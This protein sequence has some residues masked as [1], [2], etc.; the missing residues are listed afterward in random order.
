MIRRIF[1]IFQLIVVIAHLLIGLTEVGVFTATAIWIIPAPLFL[2]WGI[3]KPQAFT[4]SPRTL[5]Y[6]RISWVLSVLVLVAYGALL[7]LGVG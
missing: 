1:R 7:F 2:L 3:V 5:R 6:L 4:Q